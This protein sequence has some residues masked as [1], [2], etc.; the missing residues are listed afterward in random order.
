LLCA[1]I[2]GY[3]GKKCGKN[4]DLR[5]VKDVSPKTYTVTLCLE[6]VNGLAVACFNL[7]HHIILLGLIIVY[8]SNARRGVKTYLSH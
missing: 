5:K 6:K 1:N 2:L 4:H 3:C 8:N 7:Y